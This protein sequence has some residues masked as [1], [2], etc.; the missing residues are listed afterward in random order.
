MKS[1][2]FLEEMAAGMRDARAVGRGLLLSAALFV[3]AL[4]MASCGGIQANR[5]Q[6]KLAA[7]DAEGDV[8][9]VKFLLAFTAADLTVAL[10]DARAHNDTVSA[11]CW[12]KLLEKVKGLGDPQATVGQ[13]AGAFSAFQKKRDLLNSPNSQNTHNELTI[14][15]APLIMDERQAILAIAGKVGVRGAL[16]SVG[17]PGL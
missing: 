6:A 10:A 17:I 13:V 12:E 9:P 16:M 14:A 11:P 3:V 5:E 4:V 8:D 7:T 2:S 1:L 15:C